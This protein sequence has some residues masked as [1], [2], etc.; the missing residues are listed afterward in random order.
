MI[1]IILTV[2]LV[3]SVV[4]AFVLGKTISIAD[5]RDRPTK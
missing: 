3:L 1:P 4:T 2:W 5:Q